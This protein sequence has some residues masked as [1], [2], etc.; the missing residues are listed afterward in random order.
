MDCY[1]RQ[2]L[3][4]SLLLGSQKGET[5]KMFF[6]NFGP[7]VYTR[8]SDEDL[9]EM[10]ETLQTTPNAGDRCVLGGLRSR[11]IRI[12]CWR[13]R[14][15]LQQLDPVGWTFRHRCA[16]RQRKNH[17]QTPNQLWYFNTLLYQDMNAQTVNVL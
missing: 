13:V 7:L 2:F 3:P 11:H 4:V 6:P 17:V 9:T 5:I 14:H 10:S 1:H 12:Q 15:C 8:M 16:I